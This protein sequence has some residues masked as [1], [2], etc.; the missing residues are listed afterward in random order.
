MKH[1]LTDLYDHLFDSLDL[2]KNSTPV[3]LEMNIKRAAA[4][5]QVS[6]TVIEAAKLE[7]AAHKLKKESRMDGLFPNLKELG[8][9]EALAGGKDG[10]TSE[11]AND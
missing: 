9:G 3:A 2:L 7:V 10:E 8:T 4:I 6:Q 1:T 11:E 5:R